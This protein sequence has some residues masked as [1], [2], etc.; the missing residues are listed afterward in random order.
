MS[1]QPWGRILAGTEADF[2]SAWA[3]FERQPVDWD[4]SAEPATV[5]DG[6]A[7]TLGREVTVEGRGTF[8]RKIRSQLRLEPTDLEGWW[9]LRDD[10]PDSLPVRVSVRNVWTTG[11]VV[12]NIVLRS[13]PPNN[14][15]RMV[16][17]IIALRLGLDVDNLLIRMRSG[18]PPLFDRGS[19]ELVQAIESAGTRTLE[20]PVAYRTVRERVS[21]VTPRGNF[22]VLHPAPPGDRSLTVDCAI[23]FK[24]AIGR[25]RIQ[26]RLNRDRFKYGA[27]ARTN[28]SFIK[29]LYCR[30]IGRIQAD[31]RH[32]GYT[33]KNILIASRF[34]YVNTPGLLHE[35]KSLEAVW[36][37]ATLDLL[38]ALALI[39]DGRFCGHV[40]SY[41]A[42]HALD[43]HLVRLLYKHDL[44]VPA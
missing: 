41:C 31:I 40:T 42:G 14:Y 44:L 39:E 12:S 24:T 29:M 26:F 18:D 3:R 27:L 37:R 33:T 13:G 35:G 15:V 21:I 10:L 2:S 36:H 43:C 9:F 8:R 6:P 20:R 16:E 7:R 25:Q 38:A 34:G 23:D 19:E 1:V 30:T 32:L 4:L 17:H 5:H 22:L 11:D 28:T